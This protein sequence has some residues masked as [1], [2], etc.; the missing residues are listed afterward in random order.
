MIREFAKETDARLAK[1]MPVLPEIPFTAEESKE[2]KRLG[3][4]LSTAAVEAHAKGGVTLTTNLSDRVG[5]FVLQSVAPIKQREFLAEM[6]LGY[7][8]SYLEAFIKDYILQIL[9]ANPRMLRSN[10]TMTFEDVITHKSMKALRSAVA[11]KEVES[12]GYGS[13]DE[14]ATYFQKKLNISL[15]TFP[16]WQELRE[17]VF[18][19]NLIVHN[20]ARVNETYRRKVAYTGKAVHIS[21]DMLYVEAAAARM[22]EFM[23]FVHTETSKK[24]KLDET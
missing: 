20:K 4:I 9:V 8:I 13:I 23:E 2:L 16:Q 18:R 7:L 12:L 22:L 1:K 19:R 5:K 24:L 11:E 15:T 10:A 21:T 14:V 6:A 3:E 17:H